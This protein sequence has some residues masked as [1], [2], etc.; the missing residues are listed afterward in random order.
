MNLKAKKWKMRLL[1]PLSP[2]RTVRLLSLFFSFARL[3]VG[4]FRWALGETLKRTFSIATIYAAEGDHNYNVFN[5]V[6][7]GGVG[8]GQANFD[9]NPISGLT[10]LN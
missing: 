5:L 3:S 8:G 7:E 6:G 1:H 9:R 2:D 4:S 10:S